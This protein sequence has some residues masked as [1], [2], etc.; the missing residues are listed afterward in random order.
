MSLRNLKV[1]AETPKLS[2]T[3]MID[4][5]F[6]LLAFFIITFRIPAVEGDFNIKMPV[7]AQS[8]QSVSM[9]EMTPVEIRLTAGPGGELSGIVFGSKALG[10]DMRALRAEIF[11][12]LHLDATGTISQGNGNGADQEVELNCDPELRYRYVIDAITAVTGYVNEDNQIVK[13][14]E[15]VKFTPP[16]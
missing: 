1:E 11:S 7:N 13:L 8:S 12:F 15:K 14:I 3:P 5:V 9:D 2:M 10:T 16:K 4:I 6:N